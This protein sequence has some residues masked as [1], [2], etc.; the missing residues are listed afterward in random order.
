MSSESCRMLSPRSHLVREP[1]LDESEVVLLTCTIRPLTTRRAANLSQSGRWPIIVLMSSGQ[2]NPWRVYEMNVV[3]P[4]ISGMV[5]A[6][7][8]SGNSRPLNIHL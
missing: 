8:C 7:D 5:H 6:H 4:Y 2:V 3:E 1:E